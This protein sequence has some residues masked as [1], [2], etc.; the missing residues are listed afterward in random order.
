MATI[1][2]THIFGN[3]L[4]NAS[5][6]SVLGMLWM[7]Y[8]LFVGIE[9]MPGRVQ[10]VTPNYAMRGPARVVVYKVVRWHIK[11]AYVN[12]ENRVWLWLNSQVLFGA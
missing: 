12:I 7:L 6:T 11:Q 9:Y 10:L 8:F 4:L 1:I 5:Y 2:V 3:P